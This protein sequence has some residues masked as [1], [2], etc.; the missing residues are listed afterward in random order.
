M[1][2]L[3]IANYSHSFTKSHLEKVKKLRRMTA[4]VININ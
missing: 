1:S 4:V 3:F 2:K